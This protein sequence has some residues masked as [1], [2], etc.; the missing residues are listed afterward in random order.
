MYLSFYAY[1]AATHFPKQGSDK[2]ASCDTDFDVIDNAPIVNRIGVEVLVLSHFF[3]FF[4][5]IS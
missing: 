1:L 2:I 5:A 4:V 3:P